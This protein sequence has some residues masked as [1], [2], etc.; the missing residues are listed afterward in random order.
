[1]EL[2]AYLSRQFAYDA[3]ANRAVLTAIKEILSP[4]GNNP[5]RSLQLLAHIQSAER[6]WLERLTQHR[7]SLP[8]WPELNLSECE[9]QIAELPKLWQ[10][11]LGQL[12]SPALSTNIS[13]SN[14][15]GE[16]FHSSI[17]E[18]LTHVVLHSAYHRGQIATEMRAGG[19]TPAYTD[20]IHAVRQ[21]LIE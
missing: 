20:F 7:Q 15:K 11:Y 21:G 4:A 18:V 19:Y 17:E 16:S 14:S 5:T 1:M 8:V 6:L 12:S 3:W 9:I 13:Y 10:D 2:F